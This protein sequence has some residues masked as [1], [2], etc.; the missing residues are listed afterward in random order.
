MTK[1]QDNIEW[2]VDKTDRKL[3]MFLQTKDISYVEKTT[4]LLEDLRNEY[5]LLLSWK[6]LDEGRG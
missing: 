1:P 2:L 5:S 6:E 4:V 3:Q